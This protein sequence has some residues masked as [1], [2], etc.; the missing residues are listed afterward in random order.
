MELQKGKIL[1]SRI[2]RNVNMILKKIREMMDMNV[3]NGEL[4]KDFM[5]EESQP[6]NSMRQIMIIQKRKIFMMNISQ[7]IKMRNLLLV[8]LKNRNLKEDSQNYINYF[9]KKNNFC[10]I[11]VYILRFYIFNNKNIHNF[12]DEN[13]F[14]FYKNKLE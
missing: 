5:R 8:L 4:K 12:N 7:V 3:M 11:Y 1:N 14:N 13:F 9:Q 10:A 2:Q 6:K